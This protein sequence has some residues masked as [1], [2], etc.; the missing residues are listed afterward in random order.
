MPTKNQKIPPVKITLKVGDEVQTVSGSSVL[1]ALNRIKEPVAMKYMG[2]LT[3]E[4]D[5]KKTE[6][7]LPVPKVKALINRDYWKVILA[8]NL[9]LFLK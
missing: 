5:G 6:R 9:E 7:R 8:K 4:R 1:S 3:V 2:F